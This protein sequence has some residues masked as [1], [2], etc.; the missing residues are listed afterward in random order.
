M[1]KETIAKIQIIAG[2]L[3]IITALITNYYFKNTIMDS[4]QRGSSTYLTTASEFAREN[5]TSGAIAGMFVMGHSLQSGI[6]IGSAMFLGV[7]LNLIILAQ[8]V[9]LILSGLKCLAKE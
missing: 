7:L 8:A 5:K 6:A 4:F 3:L 9:M 1:K 2:I